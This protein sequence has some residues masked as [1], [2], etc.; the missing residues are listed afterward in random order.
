[1]AASGWTITSNL[2]QAPQQ[3][4]Q[5]DHSIH[6]GPDL[7]CRVGAGLVLAHCQVA[8]HL[9]ART[10][11]APGW[12]HA[13]WRRWRLMVI[14]RWGWGA[15]GGGWGGGTDEQQS[16]LQLLYILEPGLEPRDA[17][18]HLPCPGWMAGQGCSQPLA[19]SRL[20]GRASSCSASTSV[21]WGDSSSSCTPGR[22]HAW[23]QAPPLPGSQQAAG[24][25]M[26]AACQADW[27]GAATSRLI[28]QG[29]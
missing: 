5:E 3:V 29:G 26:R 18:S 17:G 24:L 2:G 19:L 12:S 1:M 11:A 22:P 6:Q 25:R 7:G 21:S 10:T 20:D 15:V 28:L 13:T 27:V 4:T 8:A 16:R 9:H 14:S 23:R